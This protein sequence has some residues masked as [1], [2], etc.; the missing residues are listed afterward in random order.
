MKSENK[1]EI[2]NFL[3]TPDT[4]DVPLRALNTQQFVQSVLT[5]I[6]HSSRF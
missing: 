4:G 2:T 3:I 6:D 5:F 1:N